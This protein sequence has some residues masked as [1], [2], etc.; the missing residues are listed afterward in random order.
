MKQLWIMIAGPYRGGSTDREVWA[1]N[2][3][4]LNECA[5]EVFKKGHI[6][7]IGVNAALP[8]IDVAGMEQFEQIM[9]PISLAMAE[10]CDAVLRIGGPSAG[11]D[12]EVDVFMKKGLP[13]Y[14][15]LEDI[16][17]G[18]KL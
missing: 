16:P 10:R 4:L 6:P 9:M 8:V 18:I 17:E 12:E 15:S 1:Q 5:L 7:V 13:V 3:R 11:A 14:Y 2:H